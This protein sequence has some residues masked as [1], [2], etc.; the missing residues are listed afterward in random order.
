MNINAFWFDFLSALGAV[1]K[2]LPSLLMWTLTAVFVG[3]ILLHFPY[4]RR[5]AGR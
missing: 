2:P 3:S 4:Q 1:C 5:N